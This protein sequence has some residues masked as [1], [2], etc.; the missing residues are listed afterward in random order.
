MS[1]EIELKPIDPHD[2]QTLRKNSILREL[3]SKHTPRRCLVSVYYDTLGHSLARR[4][5]T[6]RV[7]KIGSERLQCVKMNSVATSSFQLTEIENQIHGDRP[8]LAQIAYPNVRRMIQKY[9][10]RHELVRV[11]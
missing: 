4:G 10:A 11:L 3:K 9:C 5:I 7:R 8:I 1:Q 6:L 2:V